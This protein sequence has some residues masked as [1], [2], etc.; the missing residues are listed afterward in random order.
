ME[1]KSAYESPLGSRY[2]SREMLYLFSPDNKFITWRKLW[3]ALAEAEKELGLPI[4]D[5]QIASLKEHVNDIDYDA[6]RAYEERVRH[7]VMAH[8]RAYADQ[9]D[10]NAGAILHLGATSCYLTDNTDA[11]ILRDALKLIRGKLLE[12]LR[13][14]RA[15]ALQYKDLPQLGLTHL[16]PAQP[17]TVGKRACLWMQDFLMD[18]EDLDH[19]LSTVKLLGSKGTTGTQAS[20]LDLFDGDS[21]KVLD[22]EKRI[23]KKMGLEAVYPVSGQT[24]P[25]K[26]DSRILAVL[27]G[28]AQ[29]AYKFAQDIRLLQAFHECE[30]PFGAEQIGSSA[31][32]YKRNPMRSE[33]ICSLSRHV[34]AL[35]ADTAM[36]AATQWFERTLDD[37]ANR[38]LSLP[39]AFLATDA[40]LELTCNVASGIVVYP[41][42]IEK[43]LRENMPFMATENILM[44]AVKA[45]GDRQA[46]HE[47][48]RVHSQEATKRV[49]V[50]G[51][52]ND[53]LERI[54][55]DPA[56]HLEK[57]HLEALTDPKQYTGRAA[58]QVA[59]FIGELIDPLLNGVPEIPV[60]DVRV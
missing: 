23:A 16:Q 6:A 27:S 39:E 38:R 15:F 4:T 19:A 55:N 21:E 49:R 35:E 28:I 24:Y 5:A 11:L 1:H 56:F 8:V 18:V 32:A 25:R 53:L 54:A 45:G 46:L 22:L 47:R 43:N 41:K 40:V 37:S 31:M 42:I 7:D 58:E 60:G 52:D 57:A 17:V 48:I 36:T 3:V 2:A 29:S 9:C 26:L 30:E 51:L 33:R 13:R 50:E 59:E 34:M 12:A 44:E 20:F 14:L 10:C